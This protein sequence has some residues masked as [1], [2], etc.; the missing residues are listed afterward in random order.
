MDSSVRRQI[1]DIQFQAERLIKGRPSLVEVKEF[2]QYN[3]ELKKYLLSHLKEPD[4]I[5]RVR[6]IPGILEESSSEVATKNVL[7][8]I[9]MFI[10]PSFID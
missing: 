3:E 9:L 5:E 2:N 4:L 10:A 6:Q 7:F 1:K 8:V